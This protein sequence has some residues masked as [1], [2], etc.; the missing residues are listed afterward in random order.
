[1]GVESHA[2]ELDEAFR[3]RAR[4]IDQSHVPALNHVPAKFK[5]VRRQANLH[6]KDV[7]RADW[8]QS[9]C[10]IASGETVDHL[11][12]GTVATGRNDFS[13]SLPDS[14]PRQRLCLTGMRRDVN[15]TT[16]SD[17]FNTFLPVFRLLVTCGRVENDDC[18]T[19]TKG[20]R[21]L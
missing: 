18:I 2:G 8:E 13:K 5:I 3:V 15:E 16:A 10:D 7:H 14:S 11:V 6:G 9:Q 20:G 4:K 21:G 19:H 12:D 1:M 17:R